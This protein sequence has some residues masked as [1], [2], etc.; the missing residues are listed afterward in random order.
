MKKAF[1]TGFAVVL[2][3]LM[4]LPVLAQGNLERDSAY[5]QAI[6]D[7]LAAI[8]PEAVPLFQQATAALD[9]DDYEAAQQGYQQVLELAPDF[10]DALRR[11]SYVEMALGN[12]DLSLQLALQA[13][14]R[15]DSGLNAAAVARALLLIGEAANE[16]EA[17]GWAE[18][19]VDELP[20]DEYVN[21]VL[22]DAAL[23]VEHIAD[24][25]LA[26][27]N[28]IRLEVQEPLPYY[29][30][31]LFAMDDEDWALAEQYLLQAQELGMTPEDVRDPLA[32]ARRE[33]AAIESV[34][35]N[36]EL[37]I[38]GLYALGFWAAGFV[39]LLV[40]GWVLSRLT[41]LT[42]YRAQPGDTFE[43]GGGERL[44]RSLYRVVIA[45][46]SLYY[47]ISMPLL[48][49][50]VIAAALGV[51]YILYLMFTESSR[52]SL[53]I[54]G[55][56][57]LL[58]LSLVYTVL[59][60]IRSVF[61]RPPDVAP[62]RPLRRQEAPD[63]W[64]LAE[65]VAARV[66]TR[67]IDSIYITPGAEV[68]VTERGPLLRK[69]RGLGE[70]A[71]ILGLGALPGMTQGQLKAIL[72][73]EYGHFSNRDTAGG[74]LALQV[75]VSMHQMAFQ[76][77]T[78]GLAKWYN[79]AWLFI[80]GFNRIFLRITL[81]ASRLQEI[82]AD[83]YAAVAYGSR[84]FV[85]GLKHIVRQSLAFNLQVN[86]EANEALRQN[87]ALSNVYAL[88]DLSG[89]QEDGLEKRVQEVINRPT[90]AY[91]S[92]P[93]V[94]DRIRLV[95]MIGA[96]DA[97]NSPEPVWPLL[98]DADH[99]QDEMTRILQNRVQEQVRRARMFGARRH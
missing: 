33:L 24:L 35:H 92:H 2:A 98:P 91:D 39:V 54:V 6:Y 41:I 18:M 86:Q 25:R 56:L 4:A 85:E 23:T 62:G 20:D 8:D 17:L 40:V 13:Y 3:L 21:W 30:S 44:L 28:L 1:F 79:P 51:L 97:E 63:L 43:I 32:E 55:G 64:A 60:V 61:A 76:L 75:R 84:L 48:V 15:D 36:E 67:P 72:A 59:A 19:A 38:A 99:L 81:G 93:A 65:A 50:V 90:A 31:G 57:L 78:N 9:A 96:G 34:R 89:G 27:A 52:I 53:R 77:A 83:R 12:E 16:R 46:T 37:V 14:D 29:L 42:A 11:L 80:N 47:Y 70:R 73:H 71:L 68:A 5:E 95:E 82:L 10:P 58:A 26:C 22:L 94:R 74:N 87:R 66:E 7:R 69:L 49:I 45:I 88:S